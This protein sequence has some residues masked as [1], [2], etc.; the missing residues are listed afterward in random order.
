ME[1]LQ[2]VSFIEPV[3]ASEVFT[4]FPKLFIG[5]GKLKDN[6]QIKL[7]SDA[8]PYTLQVPRRVALPLLPKVEAELQRMEAIG[9]ISK[10]EEPTEWCSPW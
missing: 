2:V 5:L 3:Q 8:K 9:V 10:I 1:A 6:Y 7:R 4:L